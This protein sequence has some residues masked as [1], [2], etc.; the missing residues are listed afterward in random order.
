MALW[1]VHTASAAIGP[2]A[3]DRI[4][5][6]HGAGADGDGAEERREQREA[7]EPELGER[8]ELEGVR[9]ADDLVDVALAQ[10]GL[11]EAARADARE[12][13]VEPGVDRHAPVV[14]A[15]GAQGGEALVRRAGDGR[16]LLV[17]AGG[18]DR[19]DEQRRDRGQRGPSRPARQGERA[20]GRRDAR[21]ERRERGEDERDHE[22]DRAFAPRGGRASRR[23]PARAGLSG[24]GEG[25][26]RARREHER[27][28]A[29]L[30]AGRGQEGERDEAGDERGQRPA[31]EAQVTAHPEGDGA[32]CRARAQAGRAG[33]VADHARAQHEPDRGQRA[34][35]VP[36]GQRLVQAPGGADLRVLGDEA[37]Q[38]ATRQA[39]A[40]DD[41]GAR[42]GQRLQRAHRTALA[43]RGD[44]GGQHGG[45]EQGALGVVAGEVAHRRPRGRQRDPGGVAQRRREGH[46]RR[47]V[48]RQERRPGGRQQREHGGGHEQRHVAGPVEEAAG[49][50]GEHEGPGHEGATRAEQAGRAHPVRGPASA[51]RRRR[52]A[53]PRRAGRRSRRSRHSRGSSRSRRTRC[54]RCSRRSR[55]RR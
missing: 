38:Q 43:E 17:A 33:L 29:Q 53:R 25:A 15:V 47:R 37:G 5:P 42:R 28:G 50:E 49:V 55:S 8:L 45:V 32:R 2:A 52:S 7:D 23:A 12:R 6:V 35:R 3:S 21:G 24:R 9:V 54:S 48:A 18:D 22:H 34:G 11:A 27:R 46:A 10:P 14:V 1:N 36:V 39:V 40:D 16:R 41:D 30:R 26:G 31:R 13:V 19:D 4:G 51:G 44:R 20:V